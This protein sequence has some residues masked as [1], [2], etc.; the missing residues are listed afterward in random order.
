L[1]Y[2]ESKINHV[3]FV[4]QYDDMSDAEKENKVK[5]VLKDNKAR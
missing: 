1:Y 5:K 4:F 2:I 3:L